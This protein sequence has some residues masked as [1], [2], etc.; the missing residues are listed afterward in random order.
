LRLEG[1]QSPPAQPTSE[2]STID[3]IHRKRRR[4]FQKGGRESRTK[5]FEKEHSA[6]KRRRG[7]LWR[8]R[9]QGDRR[10]DGEEK[11]RD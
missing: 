9:P 6:K 5:L 7:T 3:N 4:T 1:G 10:T 8:G 2:Y 11:E